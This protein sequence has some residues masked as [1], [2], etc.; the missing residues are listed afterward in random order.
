MGGFVL[1]YRPVAAAEVPCGRTLPWE[2]SA[3]TLKYLA[4][5]VRILVSKF[6]Q[7][8]GEPRFLNVPDFPDETSSC[9][10]TTLVDPFQL[11]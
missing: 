2:L 3:S 11:T 5:E 10:L 6:D 4:L 8:T 9:H 7:C 1:R